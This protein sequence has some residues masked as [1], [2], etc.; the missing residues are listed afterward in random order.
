MKNW[1]IYLKTVSLILVFLLVK[2]SSFSQLSQMQPVGHLTIFSEN[3]ERFYVYLNGEKY[4]NEPEVNLRIEDLTSPYYNCKIVFED[5]I[6]PPISKNRLMICD[7]NSVMQDVTYR[8]KEDRRGNLNLTVFSYVPVSQ[9]Y[10]RPSNCAVYQ[11]GSPRRPMI[12]SNGVVYSQSTY[13][14]NTIGINAPGVNINVAVPGVT[15]T[16]TTVTQY[17]N[18][19]NQTI[20]QYPNHYNRCGMQMTAGNFESAKNTIVN[21]G[22]DETRLSTAKQIVTSN[23]MSANQIATILNVF[24]FESTKLD[25][26]K[27]AYLYC[28]DKGNYFKVVNSFSYES[29]KIELNKY[30]Q[31]INY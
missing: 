4:N 24:S 18:Y 21:N 6:I 19:P 29:S 31:N 13:S 22:F 23:C 9:N 16:T 27:F 20:N 2:K 7:Y 28:V 1:K 8:I 12:G 11:Y 5:S 17:D 26:A 15:T 25:F 3:G 30:I 10:V 14:Q